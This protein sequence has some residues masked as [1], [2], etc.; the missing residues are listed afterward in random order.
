MRKFAQKLVRGN[1]DGFSLM[2]LLVAIGIMAAIAAVTVPL[3]TKFASS[4][5]SGAQ[6]AEKTNVQ[7]AMDTLMAEA[8][9]TVIDAKKGSTTAAVLDWT[10][11]PLKGSAAIQVGGAD[12][13]LADYM[14][15]TTAD[16]TKYWYCY[17]TD[18]KI[19]EQRTTAGNCA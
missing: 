14:R 4:G 6:S 15:M 12:V 17:D 9:V 18:G 8:A 7:T 1:E 5:E 11:L 13:D 10:G 19:L 16:E 3:V 2:E